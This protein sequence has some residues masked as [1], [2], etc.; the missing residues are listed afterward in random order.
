MNYI[1]VG[2]SGLGIGSGGTGADWEPRVLIE[3]CC[4]Q[5]DFPSQFLL[6]NPPWSFLLNYYK[7]SQ[8]TWRANQHSPR[9]KDP[10]FRRYAAGVPRSN[11]QGQCSS[12]CLLQR[13][14]GSVTSAFR[15]LIFQ[16]FPVRMPNDSLYRWTGGSTSISTYKR[17][18]QLRLDVDP[19]SGEAR[20]GA[21]TTSFSGLAKFT[22]LDHLRFEF[23]DLSQDQ[24]APED[25]TG[26]DPFPAPAVRFTRR[27][28]SQPAHVFGLPEAEQH[29]CT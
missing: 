21:L 13:C 14:D 15:E 2:D 18:I 7:L 16:G 8:P 12:L 25:P 22:N 20:R 28:R 10:Q 26:S 24:I 6:L 23:H 11:S 19:K 29:A 1:P 4:L 9:L 17:L 27:A 5:T 3:N